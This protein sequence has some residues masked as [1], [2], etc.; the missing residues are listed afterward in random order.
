MI[1]KTGAQCQRKHRRHGGHL[2]RQEDKDELGLFGICS[3]VLPPRVNHLNDTEYNHSLPSY[4]SALIHVSSHLY[5]ASNELR[6][7]GESSQFRFPNGLLRVNVYLLYCMDRVEA[8]ALTKSELSSL[9]F[10][11]KLFRTNNIGVV[12]SCQ[13]YFGLCLSSE[14]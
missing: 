2:F 14:L 4:S 6:S 3:A 5:V 11:M 9:N 10:V 7:P 13:S 12:K 1:P 8:C